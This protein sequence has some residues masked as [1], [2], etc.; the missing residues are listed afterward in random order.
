[1]GRDTDIGTPQET[2]LKDIKSKLVPLSV[3]DYEDRLVEDKALT[4]SG[5]QWSTEVQEDTAGTEKVAFSKTID[6]DVDS[7]VD[8]VLWLEWGLTCSVKSAGTTDAMTY[9]WQA[10][11]QGG[12]WTDL[13]A[14]VTVANGGADVYVESTRQGFF[15]AANIDQVPFEVQMLIKSAGAT[16]KVTGKV[17]SSSYVRAVYRSA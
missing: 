17:K 1:M 5:E 9:K 3:V 12:T 2:T 16:D 11:N 10:R 6:P 15:K 7:A 14:Y 8:G 13:H 4:A